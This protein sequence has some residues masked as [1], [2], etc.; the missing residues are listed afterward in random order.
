MASAISK[1]DLRA[2]MSVVRTYNLCNDSLI[3][4]LKPLGLK[5]AQ[6]EVLVR[7]LYEPEQTQQK[8]AGNSYVVKS[9]MSGLLSEMMQNGWVKRSEHENDKRS[10]LISLTPKGLVLAK[11]AAAVQAMVV[12]TMFEDLTKKQIKETEQL[13]NAVSQKLEKFKQSLK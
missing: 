3:S 2:W 8:L 4:A 9:H 6:F 11:K 13:M 12:N 1:E 10:K 5:L 7:L